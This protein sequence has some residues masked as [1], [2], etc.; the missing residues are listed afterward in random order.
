MAR[1]ITPTSACRVVR[2]SEV[3]NEQASD[4]PERP[5]RRIVTLTVAPIVVMTIGANVA[6]RIWTA[7]VDTQ[8]LLLLVLNPSNLIMAAVAPQ[9]SAVTFFTV[10]VFRRLMLDPLYFLLGRW[11]GSA[12]IRWLKRK[13]P[14]IGQLA[15]T[16][17]KAFPRYG[18]LLIFLYPHP[19]VMFLAAMSGM[20][21]RVFLLWDFAGTVFNT[22]LIYWFGDRV[23]RDQITATTSWMGDHQKEF[24]ILSAVLLGFYLWSLRK[25]KPSATAMEEELDEEADRT[26]RQD[27]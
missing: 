4:A 17:E 6:N 11:Y 27:M 19:I 20:R 12:A 23:A 21:M 5:S 7:T 26:R 16:F 10:V 8:P 15:G 13:S 3:P 9:L 24:A 25:Q 22:V 1:Q 14:E 18:K 2:V